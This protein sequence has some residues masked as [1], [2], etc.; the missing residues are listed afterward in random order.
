MPPLA[1]PGAGVVT[2]PRAVDGVQG[3]IA[4]SL[5]HAQME[6]QRL[7][8]ESHMAFLRAFEAAHL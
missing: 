3:A 8:A 4:E 2:A 7:M 5:L 1:A 6:Y